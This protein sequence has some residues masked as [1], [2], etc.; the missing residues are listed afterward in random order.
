MNGLIILLKS[1]FALILAFTGVVLVLIPVGVIP[2]ATLTSFLYSGGGEAVLLAFGALM[3]VIG[4]YFLGSLYQTYSS[5][6]HFQQEGEWGKIEL[7][8]AAL[9]EFVSVIL[10]REIGIDR[11]RV[12]LSHV[13][14]GIEIKVETTLSADQQVAEVSRRIQEV[15]ATRIK[16]RTGVEVHRV[17]VLVR[18]IRSVERQPSEERT[19][20]D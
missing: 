11:F 9:R 5:A 8:P 17:S 12:Y 3:L 14:D 15:L 1:I 2:A 19:D 13:E 7:S 18:S 10:H 16:E 4:A 20:E 6:G